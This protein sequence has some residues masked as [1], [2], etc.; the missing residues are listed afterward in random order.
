MA[1]ITSR[2]GGFLLFGQ[3]EKLS[4]QREKKRKRSPLFLDGDSF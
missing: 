3:Q 1:R 4:N 2:K